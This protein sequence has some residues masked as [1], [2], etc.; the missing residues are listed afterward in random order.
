MNI[1]AAVLAAAWTC[2]AETTVLSPVA[3]TFINGRFPE[4][5]AGGHTW[6][7]AGTDRLMGVRRGLLR[8]DLSSIPAGSVVTSAVLT[9]QVAVVP[10]GGS[11]SSS[12]CDA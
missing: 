11:P 12:A 1:C 5:N 4:N 7:D 10:P 3:D 6:F 9:L 8:F 2:A